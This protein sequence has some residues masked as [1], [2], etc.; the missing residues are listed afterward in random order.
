[1]DLLDDVSDEMEGVVTKVVPPLFK[2]YLAFDRFMIG[3]RT[4]KSEK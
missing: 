4:D 3:R 1:M 2:V